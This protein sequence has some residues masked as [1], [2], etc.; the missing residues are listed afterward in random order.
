MPETRDIPTLT[1]E[2]GRPGTGSTDHRDVEVCPRDL[3]VRARTTDEVQGDQ[4]EAVL[5][6]VEQHIMASQQH[7]GRLRVTAEQDQHH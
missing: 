3:V 5:T 1:G 2:P 7:V 6:A 4:V